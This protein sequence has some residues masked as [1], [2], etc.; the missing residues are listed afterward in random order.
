MGS[1]ESD[2][3]FLT[4]VLVYGLEQPYLSQLITLWAFWMVLKND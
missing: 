1:L 3:A 4:F 2:F